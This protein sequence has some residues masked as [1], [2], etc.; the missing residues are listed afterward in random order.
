LAHIHFFG[1]K[2]AI[3][4]I[5]PLKTILV[6]EIEPNIGNIFQV[7]AKLFIIELILWYILNHMEEYANELQKL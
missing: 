2:G 6:F 4:S 3:Y 5:Y 1:S 7:T